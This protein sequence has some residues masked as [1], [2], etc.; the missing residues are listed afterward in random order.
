MAYK[1]HRIS[2]FLLSLTNIATGLAGLYSL[3]TG[4]HSSMLVHNGTLLVS[5]LREDLWRDSSDWTRVSCRYLVTNYNNPAALTRSTWWVP[6]LAFVCGVI[7]IFGIGVW[8]WGFTVIP[9]LSCLRWWHAASN[10]LQ[11]NTIALPVCLLSLMP[12]AGINRP[13]RPV[14]KHFRVNSAGSAVLTA[15]SFFAHRVRKRM[16]LS[17]LVS[18]HRLTKMMMSVSKNYFLTAAIASVVDLDSLSMH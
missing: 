11:R 2:F 14:V 12:K 6:S 10:R 4:Y 18:I 1:N 13:H 9:R 5:L 7:W 17:R 16:L 15:F 3:G 8:M